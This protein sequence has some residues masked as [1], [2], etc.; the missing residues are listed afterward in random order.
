MRLWSRRPA[1]TSRY[2]ACGCCGR[3]LPHASVHE[4]SDTPGTYLCRRCALWIATRIKR[5]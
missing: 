1:D 3:H 4:L 2:V 5:K